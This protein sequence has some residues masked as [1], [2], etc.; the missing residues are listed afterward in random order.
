[1]ETEFY[2][3]V[4]QVLALQYNIS[5]SIKQLHSEDGECPSNTF[6]AGM[7]LGE[8]DEL[9]VQLERVKAIGRGL[10]SEINDIERVAEI[11]KEASREFK[12]T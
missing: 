4:L 9:R 2:N 11:I 12:P 5:Q 1:M 7:R 8:I 3:N 10:A 6:V